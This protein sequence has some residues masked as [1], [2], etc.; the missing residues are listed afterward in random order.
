MISP[1][2]KTN[3]FT[4]KRTMQKINLKLWGIIALVF[5]IGILMAQDYRIQKDDVVKTG[6]GTV[7]WSENQLEIQDC[8]V[9]LK[10]ASPDNFEMSFSVMGSP[11]GKQLQA[12]AGFGYSDRDN[13][14]ALGLRGGNN[15]DLY[16]H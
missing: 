2:I 12:W 15:N 6:R 1:I 9:T 4:V 5:Q 11:E 8:F 7:S 16:L 3:Q 10:K 14:Y 13:R